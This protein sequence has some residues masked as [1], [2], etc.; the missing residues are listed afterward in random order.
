MSHYLKGYSITLP[1][2]LSL[3]GCG[4]TEQYGLVDFNDASAYCKESRGLVAIE[5]KM[6]PSDDTLN[7][8]A[9][10]GAEDGVVID[11]SEVDA[12][13]YKLINE[14]DDERFITVPKNRFASVVLPDG[15]HLVYW[16]HIVSSDL[17]TLDT[18]EEDQ[19]TPFRLINP[20]L[21]QFHQTGK[22][23]TPGWERELND[24]ILVAIRENR[25][26]KNVTRVFIHLGC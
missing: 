10:N 21:V 22:L 1:L 8:K 2:I 26:F 13:S 3:T 20:I 4:H 23:K 25:K 16:I 17:A 12:T 15:N 19:Q 24:A 5:S 7:A 18:I 14:E 11:A 6:I 9:K